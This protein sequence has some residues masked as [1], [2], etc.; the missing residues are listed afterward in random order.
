MS[1]K[2]NGQTFDAEPRPGQCLRTFVRDLSINGGVLE[3]RKLLPLS[4]PQ[5]KSYE[6]L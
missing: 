6:K 4:I 1:Y 3:W 5:T 2:I